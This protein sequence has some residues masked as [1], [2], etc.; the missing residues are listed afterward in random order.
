MKRH[1]LAALTTLTLVGCDGADSPTVTSSREVHDELELSSAVKRAQQNL[2]MRTPEEELVVRSV[3]KDDSGEEHVRFD[4]RYR[5]LR[6][7]GGDFVVH[8]SE[9][10]LLKSVTL[11]SQA[12]LRGLDVK[13]VF[14]GAGAVVLAEKVFAGQRQGPGSAE[15]VIDARE[16]KAAL[17]Y[18]VILEGLQE[19]GATPSELHVLVDAKTGQIREKWEGV[20]TAAATGS[21][22]SLYS[23]TVSIGTNSVSGGYELRDPSRGGFYT[24]NYTTNAVFK[25]TDNVW[26][27]GTTSDTATAGVDA[28]YGQQVTYDYYLNVHGRNGINGTGGT[29]YSRVHYGT[30]YNNAFWQ[31]SCFCMT[32]GDGD[33]STF[34][35]LIS[36]DV[37]GHEMTHGVTSR[38]AGLVYSGESGG[39][40]EATSDIFGSLVEFYAANAND[41]G[42]FLIGEE[43]YTPSKSGDALRYMHKPSLDGKSP[44]CYSSTVGNLDVHASSGIANHFFYLLAQGSNANPVSPTCNGAAVTGIG[45]DKA[46]KIWYRALTVKMTS[47]TKYAGARTA[48]LAAATDLYGASSA[49][50]NAVNAAWAAVNVK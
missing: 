4:K 20:H 11:N 34:T 12:S 18:E 30:R 35:P 45:K 43:I 6:T 46:G 41:P 14:D 23:G 10:G 47:S 7:I 17:A 40:N 50:Y 2:G 9:T 42:D 24:V 8:Q 3:F 44:D 21:G 15:L 13:P 49:E 32:Y 27:N 22:K 26:G 48:T 36:L 19:D 29:G 38:T 28:H 5:G 33:G 25:D 16:D 1:L 37:A 31:D 39:L